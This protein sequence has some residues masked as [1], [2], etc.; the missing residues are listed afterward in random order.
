ML[1]DGDAV[2]HGVGGFAVGFGTAAFGK[3]A[4]C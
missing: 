2:E 4:V 3:E 1:A